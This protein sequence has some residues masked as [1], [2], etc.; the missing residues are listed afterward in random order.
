VKNREVEKGSGP[1]K[2][3]RIKNER[4][5]CDQGEKGNPMG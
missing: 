2:K 5:D 3:K 1:L 4:Y